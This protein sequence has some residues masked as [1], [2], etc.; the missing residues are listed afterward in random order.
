MFFIKG[1]FTSASGTIPKCHYGKSYLV[2]NV[3]NLSHTI[4][5]MRLFKELPTVLS[6][7]VIVVAHFLID[8]YILV[9][10]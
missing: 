4:K 1:F 3:P 9:T 6:I 7:P 5:T 10:A 8:L 2:L